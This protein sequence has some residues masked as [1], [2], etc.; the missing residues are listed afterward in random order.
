MNDQLR[1]ALCGALAVGIM[2]CG[3]AD[4]PSE[5][6]TPE[7]TDG[8]ETGAIDDSAMSTGDEV[9]EPVSLSTV[10]GDARRGDA[11]AR[12]MYRHPVE[13]LEFFG[14][15]P[16]MT[17]VEAW[18]GGGWYSDILAPYLAA[19][20]GTLYAAHFDPA[21][22]AGYQSRALENFRTKYL[23]NPEEYGDVRMTVL[24]G[25][26]PIAPAGSA[27]MVLTFRNVHNWVMGGTAETIFAQFYD[28]LEPGGVLG[29]VDHRL[30][31][32][33]SAEM[34]KSSGYVKESTVKALAEAAGFEFVEASEVNAN[35]ADT[36]DHP[37]GV[38]TLP[39]SNRRPR[40][41][42]EAPEGFDPATF[43]AIGE[44]DRM[45]LK[46]RKPIMADGALLE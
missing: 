41:G 46:F 33:A 15:E 25:S 4:E 3:P 20:G 43:E 21:T 38:W 13:T 12:D 35:A 6:T 5:P 26:E 1:I 19:G 28:A 27:D 31:E 16:D 42:E 40:D 10:I 22:A 44:S 29:V 24:G 11:A 30:P 34:E 14:I 32:E 17:V 2:G 36:A 9:V 23:E 18:P 45:T 37:Y 39:P 8:T 7:L